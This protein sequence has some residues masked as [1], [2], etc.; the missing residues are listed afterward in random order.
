[1]T[2]KE[3]QDKD[4]P[5]NKNMRAYNLRHSQQS[6]LPQASIRKFRSTEVIPGR[7]RIINAQTL[8]LHKSLSSLHHIPIQII[9]EYLAGGDTVEDVLTEFPDLERADILACLAYAAASM[10]LKDIEVPAA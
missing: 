8:V 10:K 4:N 1:L 9:T 6:A 3:V 2:A 7:M 5:A